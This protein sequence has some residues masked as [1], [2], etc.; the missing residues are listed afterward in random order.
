MGQLNTRL[1]ADE[2]V[3]LSHYEREMRA[4]LSDYLIASS[5]DCQALMHDIYKRVTG[6]DFT[7]T[8]SCGSCMLRLHKAVAL[9]W[10]CTAQMMEAE[11]KAKKA[12]KKTNK[13]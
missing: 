5:R 3:A 11:A 2:M 13:K 1:T 9:W 7:E 4:A 8:D 10:E 12:E 6:E